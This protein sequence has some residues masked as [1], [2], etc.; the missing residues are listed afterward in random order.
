MSLNFC[1]FCK[2]VRLFGLFQPTGSPFAFE[3]CQRCGS[4]RLVADET[5]ESE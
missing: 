3:L 1:V 2:A 5:E 4:G